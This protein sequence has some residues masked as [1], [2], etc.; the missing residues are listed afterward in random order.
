[1][2]RIMRK[3]AQGVALAACALGMASC[4]DASKQA[5]GAAG[6]M[7]MTYKLMTVQPTNKAFT[8]TYSGAVR[9]RYDASILPQVSGT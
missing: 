1:M 7:P 6:Q 8:T 5:A 9:G 4:G 2:I 3:W